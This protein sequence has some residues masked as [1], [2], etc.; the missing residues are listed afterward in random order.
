MLH[1]NL[2]KFV[3]F[4][5]VENIQIRLHFPTRITRP[6]WTMDSTFRNGVGFFWPS[7]KASPI[8][9]WIQKMITFSAG[10]TIVLMKKFV[11][12]IEPNT[13]YVSQGTGRVV[14]KRKKK[15][16]RKF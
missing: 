13:V 14:L 7:A 15:T 10:A 2:D 6:I 8:G 12:P 9:R 5:D 1:E 16:E 3:G 11:D 4:R